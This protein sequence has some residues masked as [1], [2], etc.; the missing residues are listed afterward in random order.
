[1]WINGPF[2]P[3]DWPDLNIARNDIYDELDENEMLLADGG[4]SSADGYCETPNGLVDADQYMKGVARA[5]HETVNRLFKN[6]GILERRFRHRVD[7]HGRVF[8]AVAN[9][10]Q[11]SLQLEEPT[12]QVNYYDN[13]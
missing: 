11:A 3:G 13:Y 2:P 7:L 8:V 12:F 5:R 9:L 4:Y 6:W 10:V 1:M